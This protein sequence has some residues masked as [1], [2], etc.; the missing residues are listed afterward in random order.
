MAGLLSQRSSR[1]KRCCEGAREPVGCSRGAVATAPG[2]SLD[3]LA[4]RAFYSEMGTHQWNV[5]RVR[6][7]L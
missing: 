4:C 5:S 3:D 1:R 7:V 6:E 2:S